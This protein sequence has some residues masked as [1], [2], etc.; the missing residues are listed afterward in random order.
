MED[1]HGEQDGT[2]EHGDGADRGERWSMATGH[3]RDGLPES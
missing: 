2:E 1:R 3:A